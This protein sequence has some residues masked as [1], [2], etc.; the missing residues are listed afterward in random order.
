[1]SHSMS[2]VSVVIVK[3]HTFTFVC[4]AAFSV[5]LILFFASTIILHPSHTL[6]SYF[7]TRLLSF[8]SIFSKKCCMCHQNRL[9][10][11][12]YCTTLPFVRL[13]FL[14][15]FY[16]WMCYCVVVYLNDLYTVMNIPFK[17]FVNIFF[18]SY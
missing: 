6:R 15:Q 17:M 12:Y 4:F 8:S 18:Y 11:K 14:N 3:W 16:C 10:S 5:L 9:R 1:M 2:S 13:L 7:F